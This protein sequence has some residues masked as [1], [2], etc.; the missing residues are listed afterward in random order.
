MGALHDT[1]FYGWTQEQAAILRRAAGARLNAPVGLDWEQL[2]EEVEELGS[3]KVDELH[4][5]YLV[6]LCHLLKWR[7]Q[8]RGRGGSWRGTIGEQRRRLARLLGKNPSLRPKRQAE[9]ADA[10][11]DAREAA[12]DESG[13][14]LAV[15]PETCPFTIEQAE[16]PG[17]WPNELYGDDA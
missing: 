3:A 15:F 12:A 14:A 8:P 2:A 4:S 11:A 10:Y 17:Y 13:L 1:D 16:D 7:L 6:L 9:F 5:R